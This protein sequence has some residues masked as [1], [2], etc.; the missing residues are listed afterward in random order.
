[1]NSLVFFIQHDHHDVIAETQSLSFIYSLFIGSQF[2]LLAASVF[3]QWR[4]K[5]FEFW[6]AETRFTGSILNKIGKVSK[7][8]NDR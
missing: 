8:L 2:H 3:A 7:Y 1:M 6:K 4:Q 5:N